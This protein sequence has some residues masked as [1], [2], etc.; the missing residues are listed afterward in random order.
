MNS[1]L[2]KN[3]LTSKPAMFHAKA[4]PFVQA[5]LTLN[6]PGDIYEQEADAMADRVMRMTSNE[7]VKPVT[8]LIGKSLQRKC[9]HCEEEEKREKPIMRKAEAGSS[10]MAVSSPFAYSLNASRGGGSPLPQGTKNFMEN[11]FSADFSSVK[12]HTGAEASEMSKGIDANAF[13]TGNDIYFKTGQFNPDSSSG[14]YL[15]AHELTHVLQQRASNSIPIIQR[16]PGKAG[17]GTTS[18]GHSLKVTIR[19]HASPRWKGAK[20]QEQADK[21]NLELSESRAKASQKLIDRYLKDNLGDDVKISYNIQPATPRSIDVSTGALGSEESLK[22]SGGDRTI[23]DEYYR[24]VEIV[25]ELFISTTKQ[26]TKTVP[27]K[28][29]STITNKW[30]V[31]PKKIRV[32][33]AGV[34]AG[35]IELVIRN[36]ISNKEMSG[37]AKLWGG[38]MAMPFSETGF[39]SSGFDFSTDNKIGFSDFNGT[40][41]RVETA[42][43]KL[44]VGKTKMYLVFTSLNSGAINILSK[45]G[46]GLPGGYVASGQLQMVGTDPGDSMEI[47]GTDKITVPETTVS[48]WTEGLIVNFDTASA[49]VSESRKTNISEFAATWCRR[50]TSP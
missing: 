9:A 43:I 7:T 1:L 42:N 34:G 6:E 36:P 12:I 3:N 5:K 21:L 40:L 29:K 4:K 26:V 2:H 28:H 49:E 15:L 8:G 31:L 30:K 14:K 39:S 22:L 37:V 35:G 48:T 33:A 13:T 16:A 19:A 25:F 38:G 10:G 32:M 18:T 45:W 23:D 20:S 11:A 27:P 44:G 41:V 17:F 24:R 46:V 47:P 50:L